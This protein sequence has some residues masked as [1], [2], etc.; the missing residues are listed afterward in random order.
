MNQSARD[1]YARR[2][3]TQA[4]LALLTRAF[5]ANPLDT[6]V[7]GNLASLRLRQQPWQADTARQLALHALTTPH[8]RHPYGRVEDWTT[9]AI[10]SALTGRDRDARNAWFV[11]M[12]LA[13]DLE[14]Q[15]RAAINAYARHGDRVRPSVEAMLYRV[16]SSGRSDRSPLCEWPP[17]WSG[18]GRMR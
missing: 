14:R 15:C 12:A 11:T 6:E 10:A 4:A 1:I 16:H 8:A 9:F 2:G 13:S 17:H 3:D 7:V 5:A 18:A